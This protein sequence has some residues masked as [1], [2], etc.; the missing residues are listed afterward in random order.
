MAL[1]LFVSMYL[2]LDRPYWALVSAVFLQIRPESGLVI[3]KALCQIG[4]SVIGGGVGILILALLMPYPTLALACLTLWIGLNSA[5]SS[6]V[7]NTN[8]IYGFAMSGMT[9]G[10]VVVLVMA[11]ASTASS[12]AVFAIAESRISEIAVGALCAM[13]VS[14]LLWPVMVKDSLRGNAR[15]AINKTLD[16]L[17]LELS[18]DSSHKQRHEHADQILEN[19]LVLSDYASAVTLEGPEGPGRARAANLLC[20]KIMSLLAVAQ[21]MG[22][23]P[24]NHAELVTPA[25]SR[26]L[27]YMRSHFTMISEASSFEEGYRLAKALRRTLLEHRDSF[28]DEPAIVVRLTRTSVELVTDLVMVLRAYNALENRDQTLLK[29]ARLKTHRDPLVGAINGFRTA[30]V[31]VIGA[32]FWVGTGSPAAI[33]LMIMPV[34]F[35]VVF[36]R[37]SLATLTLIL[38]RVLLGAVVAIPV[39]L[40]FGLGL[41]SRSSGDFEML[42]LVLAGP[43]FIGLLAVATRPTL[44]YGLGF[45]I[46]FTLIIQPVNHMT[47]SADYAVSTAL[48]LLTGISI[49]YWVFKLITPLDGEFMQR[50]LLKATA[51]DL[52]GIDSHQRTENW[53]NGRMGE[54]LLRLANYD[55]SSAS[56]N[57]Y[58]TDLGF[59]G[60]NLGHVSIRLR[61]RIKNHRNA[62]VDERLT[63]WQQ[64]LADTYLLSSHGK[65]SSRFREASAY[66]LEAIHADKAPDSQTAT[67]KGMFE[68][69]ALTFERTAKT[70]AEASDPE[71]GDAQPAS[72]AAAT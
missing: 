43:Y 41:L 9:A 12:Q 16:Y 29:A 27:D 11:N 7:H 66:L 48:G 37:F 58:M 70:V 55:Q 65:T 49:L 68:R 31:F 3:E 38:R 59:T 47:F 67:V 33:M 46:P 1:A 21:I 20:N 52:V 54:R 4:G 39:G 72:P 35:A 15:D 53:F 45:C 36:A 13:L 25:F 19:V 8:F 40:L 57:R 6:M 51:R 26:L 24:R 50:R 30:V 60:L 2:Q 23:F 56:A 22:R 14:R 62:V 61:K 18:P 28:V 42:V 17:A 44:P 34:V 69:L 64:V 32:G 63:E 5:A 71:S 10:L